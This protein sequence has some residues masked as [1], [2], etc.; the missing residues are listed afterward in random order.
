MPTTKVE[1]LDM[2]WRPLKEVSGSGF[3]LQLGDAF[4]RGRGEPTVRCALLVVSPV[5]LILQE[6]LLRTIPLHDEWVAI[7]KV[8]KILLGCFLKCR[9][10][11]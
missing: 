8:I 10:W 7:S 3:S 11:R 9:G 2:Y 5:E 6:H 1:S 4:W